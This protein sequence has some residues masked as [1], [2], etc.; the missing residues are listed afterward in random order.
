MTTYEILLFAHLLGAIGWVGSN[1][2]LQLFA[3]RLLGHGSGAD[4]QTF[5]AMIDYLST[6]WFIPVSLWTVV[7]GIATAVEID[8]SFGDLWITLGLTMF[9]ISFLIGLLYL[10]PQSKRV[11]AIGEDEGPESDNYR[12]GIRKMIFAS[13]IELLL[14]FTVVFVMVVRPT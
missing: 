7:F 2:L 10:A 4:L 8:V 1:I 6:R 9:A 3:V 12:A 13:R 11:H 5:F 14:L